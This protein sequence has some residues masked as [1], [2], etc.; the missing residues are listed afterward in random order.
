MSVVNA[1]LRTN[2]TPQSSVSAFETT[3]QKTLI[4]LLTGPHN[5]TAITFEC[6]SESEHDVVPPISATIYRGT[7][8]R[9]KNGA[10]ATD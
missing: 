3:P 2:L 10:K 7:F 8:P 1:Y 6:N 5:M 9:N 4:D